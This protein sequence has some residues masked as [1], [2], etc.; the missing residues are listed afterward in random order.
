MGK[1]RHTAGSYV[2]E[3]EDGNT[4]KRCIMGSW[5]QEGQRGRSQQISKR[6]DKKEEQ[7]GGVVRVTRIQ[8]MANSD[9]HFLGEKIEIWLHSSS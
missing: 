1:G 3:G 2:L 6:K 7:R 9:V 5:D 8:M 4:E